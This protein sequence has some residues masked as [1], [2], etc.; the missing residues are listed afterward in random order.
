MSYDVQTLRRLAR[1]LRAV[2]VEIADRTINTKN[3]DELFW[4]VDLELA[5]SFI[6]DTVAVL[7]LQAKA[8]REAAARSIIATRKRKRKR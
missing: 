1:S 8:R 6:E 7:D 3:P 5:A 4:T 2:K